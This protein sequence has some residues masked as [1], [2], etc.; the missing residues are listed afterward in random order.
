MHLQLEIILYLDKDNMLQG[1]PQ[2]EN[3]EILPFDF[4][5][6]CT[7]YQADMSL[8]WEVGVEL[9]GEEQ[10]PLHNADSM[11]TNVPGVF[12]LGTAAGGTQRKFSHFIE[13]SHAHIPKIVAAIQSRLD[14]G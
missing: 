6:F 12:V 7:G 9:I 8:F 1:Q 14:A 11:E 2:E 13:T 3:A 4:V 10:V 5:L